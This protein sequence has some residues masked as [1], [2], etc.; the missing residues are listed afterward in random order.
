MTCRKAAEVNRAERIAALLREA[1]APLQLHVRDDSARH[2]GH[3]GHD[4]LGSHF[5]VEMVSA[6]FNGKSRLGKQRLVYDALAS[7]FPGEIHSL[8]MHL[9]APG[10]DRDPS[11]ASVQARCRAQT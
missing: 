11:E 5:H 2:L 4:P 6:R 7:M 3:G 10:E 1:L 8:T 9:L